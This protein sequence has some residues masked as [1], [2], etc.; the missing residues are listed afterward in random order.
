[1]PER[2][3]N[4]VEALDATV[5]RAAIG[6]GGRARGGTVLAMLG[7][8]PANAAALARLLGGALEVTGREAAALV[9]ASDD[10]RMVGLSAEDLYFAEASG[11]FSRAALRGGRSRAGKCSSRPRRRTGR[12]STRRPRSPQVRRDRHVRAQRLKPAGA[13]LVELT[14]AQRACFTRGRSTI[15]VHCLQTAGGQ[16]ID[17]GFLEGIVPDEATAD[18]KAKEHDLLRDGPTKK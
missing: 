2:A 4:A 5:R 17:V 3:R 12:S 10:A 7:R 11:A 9:A 6:N 14:D 16:Y 8:K 13:A 15:A 1:M 18:G